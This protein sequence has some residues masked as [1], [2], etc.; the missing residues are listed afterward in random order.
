[1]IIYATSPSVDVFT[2]GGPAEFG[3][4]G[5]M[6][7]GL[8]NPIFGFITVVLLLRSLKVQN[9]DLEN[10]RI[11]R[12]LETLTRTLND[13]KERFRHLMDLE[14]LKD[15]AGHFSYYSMFVDIQ[16]G[17]SI[18]RY[19][20]FT[21]HADAIV[22]DIKN[23]GNTQRPYFPIIDLVSVSNMIIAT[24]AEIIHVED[25]KFMRSIHASELLRFVYEAR[26]YHLISAQNFSEL[27]DFYS[28]YLPKH[29]DPIAPPN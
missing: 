6:I 25:Y 4:F 13:G 24:Y 14:R 27:N 20:I 17:H 12:D 16:S 9:Y 11:M 1:M 21:A 29:A 18:E 5:D 15:E 7:G 28:K 22:E 23:T 26:N 8:L 3:Q 19:K 2:R 10:A